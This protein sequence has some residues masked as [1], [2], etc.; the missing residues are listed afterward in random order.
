VF[1]AAW[2][3]CW[4]Y[5]HFGLSVLVMLALLGLL[6]ASYLKL[7]VGRAPVS[8]AERWC[9]DAP[10]SIYLGWI[11]VATVANVTEYLYFIHWNGFG[12][13][14]QVWAVIMLAV[15]SLLGLLMAF[16]RR[17]SGYLVVLIWSFIGIAAKQAPFPLVANSAWVSAAFA[18]GLVVFSIVQRR[19]MA[20]KSG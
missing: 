8:T 14:G 6:I 1:N 12:I 20:V 9:V 3:V 11:T 15:A 19:R 16:T 4:H 10:F 2:L 18:L 5:N 17:D 13:D 7:N